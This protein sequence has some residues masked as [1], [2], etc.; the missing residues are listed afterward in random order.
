[1]HMVQGYNFLKVAG[2]VQEQLSEYQKEN[3]EMRFMGRMRVYV[4]GG[5][6]RGV[7]NSRTFVIHFYV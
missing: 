4:C 1:M 6:D 3:M 7:I 2:L 5:P